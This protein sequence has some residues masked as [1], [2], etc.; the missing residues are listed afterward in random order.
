[1]VAFALGKSVLAEYCTLTELVGL[2]PLVDSRRS[3]VEGVVGSVCGRP[4]MNVVPTVVRIRIHSP[5]LQIRS[6]RN[7]VSSK[8]VDLQH[9]VAQILTL[10]KFR[11][12]WIRY[13]QL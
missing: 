3:Q 13:L 12:T 1:M 6:D 8:W 2:V 10:P 5:K 11:I 7:F 9:I 4:L